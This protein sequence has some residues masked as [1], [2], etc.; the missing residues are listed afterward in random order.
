LN[1]RLRKI[2][3]GAKS[4]RNAYVKYIHWF[5]K[6]L[7]SVSSQTDTAVGT[8]DSSANMTEKDS[9]LKAVT[10]LLRKVKA[11]KVIL[12]NIRETDYTQNGDTMRY[13]LLER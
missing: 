11:N 9:L 10:V 3:L 4:A 7:L 6:Y 2:E 8:R 1:V 5:S 13:G 12:G